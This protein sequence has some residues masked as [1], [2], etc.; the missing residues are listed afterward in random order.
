MR[1]VTAFATAFATVID[2]AEVSARRYATDFL[3]R[4]SGDCV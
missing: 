3:R 4:K 1:L 2:L